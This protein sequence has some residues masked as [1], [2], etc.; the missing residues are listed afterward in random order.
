MVG[1]AGQT[2]L[3][4]VQPN[5]ILLRKCDVLQPP[6]IFQTH[7]YLT[8]YQRFFGAGKTFHRLRVHDRRIDSHG[9]AFL[10][11]RGR[12]A[13]RLEWWG[14]GIHDIGDASANSPAAAAELWH[15]IE[16]LAA[17]HHATLLAQIDARSPL[18]PL[19]ER[20]G[21]KVE[22]AEVCPVLAFPDTYAEYVSSL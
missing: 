9:A 15:R 18:I 10:M 22:D 1:V 11:S 13:R 14:A 17:L 7:P 5:S 21:W 12:T 8:T 16:K 19:A 3:T 20:A 2:H 6:T 4:K